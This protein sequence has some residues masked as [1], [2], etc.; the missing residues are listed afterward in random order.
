[1]SLSVEKKSLPPIVNILSIKTQAL[2]DFS[3]REPV[4]RIKLIFS[5]HLSAFYFQNKIFVTI[6][7]NKRPTLFGHCVYWEIRKWRMLLVLYNGKLLQVAQSIIKEC[8]MISKKGVNRRNNLKDMNA[9]TNRKS[10]NDGWC[11]V[12]NATFNNISFTFWRSHNQ[13]RTH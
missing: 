5:R 9:T 12:F 10:Q 1:M 2:D 13:W 3:F 11:M 7:T 6:N 4:V 8:L